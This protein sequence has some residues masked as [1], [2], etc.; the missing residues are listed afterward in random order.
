MMILQAPVSQISQA[1]V[2]AILVVSALFLIG[3]LFLIGIFAWRTENPLNYGNFFVVA[4][5][6]TTALFGFL[7]AFPLL[8]SGIFDDPTQVLALLSALFGAIVGLV[9]TYF[10][11]KASSDAREDA[12][13]LASETITSDRTP[14]KVSV[15]SPLPNATGVPRDTSVSATFSKDMNPATIETNTFRVVRQ[16]TL[17]PVQGA[18]AYEPATKRA[19]F[20]PAADLENGI[21]YRATITAAVK[22][23]AGNA[24]AQDRTWDFTVSEAQQE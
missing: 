16:D 5:G 9:G 20:N 21:T 11:I 19:T 6:I 22:D 1:T 4:L 12:Q 23:Q 15:V 8:V 7:L 2:I 14:P 24:M 3:L 13:K 10:G 17:A 18:I